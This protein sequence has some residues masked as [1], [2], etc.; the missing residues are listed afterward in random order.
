MSQ[1]L[2]NLPFTHVLHWG[3]GNEVSSGYD[4]GLQVFG[5]LRGERPQTTFEHRNHDAGT[6]GSRDTGE[7]RTSSLK[8]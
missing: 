8:M 6:L 5:W 1:V 3:Q 4:D 2:Q 7:L